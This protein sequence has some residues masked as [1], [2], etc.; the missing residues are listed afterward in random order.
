MNFNDMKIFVTIYETKSINK[1][2]KIL[3]YAQSN[4]S[5]RLKVIETELGC[6]LFLRN[7]NGLVPTEKG[8]LFYQFCKETSNNLENL[9]KRISKAKVTVLISELLLNHDIN[10]LHTIDLGI[11]DITIKKTSEIPSVA[12]QEDFDK[13]FC[14]QKIKNLKNYDEIL[15][16]IETMYF[17]SSNQL[18][19]K[20][21]P[22]LIN[23]DENCPLRKRTVR[24]FAHLKEF[25]EIDSFENIITLVEKGQ[26]FAL[27]PT[28]L[29][30]R[31]NIKPYTQDFVN[32]PFYQ[33]EKKV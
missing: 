25:V 18:V 29:K 6:K 21:T 16:N 1:S 33:Y 9:K 30:N 27:L 5:A 7:Y 28:W 4:L 8:D 24:E 12:Q 19:D 20:E 22:F 13:I 32:I 11:S 15:G 3:Q 17:C 2:S 10:N 23:K 26:G 31:S 14:F